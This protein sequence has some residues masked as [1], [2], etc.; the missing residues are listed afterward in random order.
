MGILSFFGSEKKES[1]LIIYEFVFSTQ[2]IC[3]PYYEA[4]RL[5]LAGQLGA[6]HMIF[7]NYS[8]NDTRNQLTLKLSL[9]CLGKFHVLIHQ[10]QRKNYFCKVFL[11][12]MSFEIFHLVWFLMKVF[13]GSLDVSS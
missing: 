5:S 2:N 3:F 13:F 4:K 1:F 6:S 11:V 7:L 12:N 9:N 10:P 8:T